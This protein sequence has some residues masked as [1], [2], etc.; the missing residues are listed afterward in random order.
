[1]TNNNPIRKT[2]IIT[3]HK[4]VRHLLDLFFVFIA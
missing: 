1:M 4:I 3:M 2:T